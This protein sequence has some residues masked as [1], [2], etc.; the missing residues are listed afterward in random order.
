MKD[1]IQIDSK[2]NPTRIIPGRNSAYAKPPKGMLMFLSWL[3]EALQEAFEPLGEIVKIA[4]G[5]PVFFCSDEYKL[6]IQLDTPAKHSPHGVRI[7]L[8]GG[9]GAIQ[10]PE[11]TFLVKASVPSGGRS[12]VLSIHLPDG[13]YVER[14]GR[15]NAEVI[16][17]LKRVAEDAAQNGWY[18]FTG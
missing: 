15:V 2:K 5:N 8:V 14:T 13:W 10:H 17:Q 12:I 3:T 4:N 18:L 16:A 1:V 11:L 7:N 9:L 6:R